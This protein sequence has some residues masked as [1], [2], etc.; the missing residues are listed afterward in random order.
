MSVTLIAVSPATVRGAAA[1]L[2]FQI[3]TAADTAALPTTTVSALIDGAATGTA[4][5]GSWA[6][7]KDGAFYLLFADDSWTEV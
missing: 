2:G 7:A 1:T 5:P 4:G 3:D 6:I